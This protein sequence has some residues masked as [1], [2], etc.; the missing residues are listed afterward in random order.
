VKAYRL[1]IQSIPKKEQFQKRNSSTFPMKGSQKRDTDTVKE[2]VNSEAK[3]SSSVGKHLIPSDWTAPP[4]S[5]LPPRARACAEQWT[6]D[7]YQ[8]EA[9]GFVLYWRSERKMKHDW[10]ATWANRII[11]RHSAVMRDQKFGNAPG[12]ATQSKYVS[13]SGYEYF[14]TPEDVARQANRRGDK[15]TYWLAQSKMNPG[16]K[17][18]GSVAEQIRRAASG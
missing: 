15:Q 1:T 8:T 17:S 14:G 6:D 4:V 10:P 11:A 13:A 9:E 7:S 3:A 18:A 16:T 12:S 2:P 5:D